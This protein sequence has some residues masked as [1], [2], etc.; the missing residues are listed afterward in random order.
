MWS[1]ENCGLVAPPCARIHMGAEF[2]LKRGRDLEKVELVGLPWWTDRCS[3]FVDDPGAE[4][5][6]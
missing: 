4:G 1:S 6:K 2:R 3:R 5:A